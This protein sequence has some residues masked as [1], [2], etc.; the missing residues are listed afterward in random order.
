MREV[1]SSHTVGGNINWSC[2]IENTWRLLKILKLERS[3][4]CCLVTKLCPT[5][6]QSHGLYSARL[7][8]RWDFPAKNTG[9]G[10][11]FLLQRIFLTQGLNTHLLDW[12]ADSS[13]LSHQV[14]PRTT[15]WPSN[16][17]ELSH[18]QNNKSWNKKD[19][20]ASFTILYFILSV[21]GRQW[22]D[23]LHFMFQDKNN[24]GFGCFFYGCGQGKIRSL[25]RIH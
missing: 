10:S 1:D 13:P 12:Q 5:L 11:H 7:L 22:E 9:V 15:I 8:C 23:M 16:P 19:S 3:G 14:G 20:V 18:G 24:M 25:R 6:L 21:M 2:H 4:C 17:T